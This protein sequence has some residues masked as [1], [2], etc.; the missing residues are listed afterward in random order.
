LIQR[1]LYEFG[2]YVLDS[3]QMILRTGESVVQLPPRVLETLLALVKRRGE[4]VTKQ[5]LMEPCGR[6]ALSKKAI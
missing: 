2:P 3:E 6:T 5:Q 1:E 4:V